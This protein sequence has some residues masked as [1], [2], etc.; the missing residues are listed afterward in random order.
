M[1]PIQHVVLC[2]GY[3][4]RDFWAGWLLALGCEDCGR[5]RPVLDR[6]DEEV[7]KPRFLFRTPGG[8]D[9]LL[10]PF[11]GSRKEALEAV[12]FYRAR[13]ATKPVGRMIF[14]RDSDATGEDAAP[15]A[16]DFVK[17]IVRELDGEVED[18]E[19]PHSIAGIRIWPVVWECPGSDPGIPPQQTLERIVSAAITSAYAGRGESV[20]SWLGDE[21]V[22]EKKNHKNYSMSY[23][24]KWYAQH[25]GY[26]NFYRALWRDPAVAGQLESR[27][28]ESGAW[29]PV[30]DLVAD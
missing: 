22:A 12:R 9:V 3:D 30:E 6:H 1:T 13:H 20:E 18:P 11:M 26:G 10:H 17:G 8:T 29:K 28:R 7:E 19:G 14:N 27:L 21:P 4:D 23:F 16:R 5:K 15:N 25:H 2:E 24:A